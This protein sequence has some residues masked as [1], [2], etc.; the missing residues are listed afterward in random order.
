ME[1]CDVSVVAS[2]QEE[3]TVSVS[4]HLDARDASEVEAAIMRIRKEHGQGSLTIDATDLAYISSAGL[5]VLVRL[6]KREGALCFANASHE[7]YDVLEMSG[8]TQLMDVRRA[9]RTISVDGLQMI[10]AGAN[11]QVYRLDEERIVKVY[12]PLTNPPEKIYRERRS[13]REA[14]VAGVPTALSFELVRVGEGLG[15]IYE[16]VDAQTLG[17]TIARTPERLEEYAAR[18]AGLMRQLHDTEFAPDELPDAR[19]SLY[20]WVD[21]AERSGFYTDEVIQA[22]RTLAHSIPPRDT[23]VHGDFHPGNIMVADD[24]F[25]L[26]DMGDASVGDPLIDLMASYQIMRVVAE[27]PGGAERY[28]GLSSDESRRVWD[29]FIRTYLDTTDDARIRAYEEELRFYML[30]RTLA[31][32]TFSTVIADGERHHLAGQVSAA[33]LQGMAERGIR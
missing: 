6:L 19:L 33:L 5:R 2:T 31:G 4:G 9:P 23:F 7:V 29:T 13:A 11:G 24:E 16:M 3:L 25:L 28:M 21:V 17:E 27:H 18:M 14:F 20:A 12:N 32:I 8:L 10:G 15:I 22:A 30:L 26:I 1:T